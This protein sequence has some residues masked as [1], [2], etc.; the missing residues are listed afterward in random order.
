MNETNAAVSE[1]PHSNKTLYCEGI[2][3][4]NIRINFC[5]YSLRLP[6]KLTIQSAQVD[7]LSVICGKP[8]KDNPKYDECCMTMEFTRDNGITESIP[9]IRRDMLVAM[10]CAAATTA[11]NNG[12][13][14]YYVPP[15]PGE[16]GI[17][18]KESERIIPTAHR[19]Q[20]QFVGQFMPNVVE[21]R[22]RRTVMQ[23]PATTTYVSRT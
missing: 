6:Q 21:P 10:Q 11:I 20:V 15:S 1:Y 13:G 17:F 4:M 12:N 16:E 8:E 18:Q 9:M 3:D 23:T 7:E 2:E 19:D 5:L 22:L 14:R